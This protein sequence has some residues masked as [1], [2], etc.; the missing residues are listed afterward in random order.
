MLFRSYNVLK[1]YSNGAI[2]F[3]LEIVKKLIMT[4]VLAVTIPHSTMAIAYGLVAMTVVEFVVNFAA[5][6]RYTSLSWWQMVKT[7]LPTLL[8]TLAMFVAVKFVACY[9]EA[10]SPILSLMVQ[11]VTGV[12][13]YTCGAWLCRLEAFAELVNVIKGVVKR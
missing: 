11:V 1:V 3:R 10:L 5:T 12:L 6:R 7:L 8:L 9:A 2:I 13:I 4:I